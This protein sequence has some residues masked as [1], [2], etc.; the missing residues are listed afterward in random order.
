MWQLRPTVTAFVFTTVP[1]PSS[2]AT[3]KD[4]YTYIGP[5]WAVLRAVLVLLRNRR[6]ER[7]VPALGLGLAW[8]W[9]LALGPVLQCLV[10]TTPD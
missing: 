10:A 1:A 6:R 4:P 2:F 7:D 3:A 9:A 5:A 8:D